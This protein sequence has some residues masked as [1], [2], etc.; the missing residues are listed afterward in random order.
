MQNNYRGK[1]KINT[2]IKNYNKNFSKILRTLRYKKDLFQHF[3][4][5]KNLF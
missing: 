1:I 2:M 5:F 4:N 3:L